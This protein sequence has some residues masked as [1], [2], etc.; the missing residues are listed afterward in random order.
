M[1]LNVT[2]AE[3]TTDDIRAVANPPLAQWDRGQILQ[4]TGVELPTAYKVEFCNKGDAVT[5]PMIGNADGVEIPN[6][7]VETGKP[8]LAYVVLY[9][10]DS[11]RETEYWITINVSVRP[12]PNDDVPDPGQ[13]SEVDQLIGALNE[14]VENAADSAEES[15]RQAGISGEYAT[16]SEAWA[17]GQRDGTDVDATDETY[18]NNSKFWSQMAQQAAGKDG[19]VSFYIDDNGHLHYVKTENAA[20]RFYIDA[21]GHLH[22]TNA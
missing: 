17:V 8:I 19:W 18:H 11:D 10:G 1:A 15:E 7:L 16:D 2:V 22:A 5:V 9:E 6:A 21:V 20:L 3:L 12:K 4:I 13:Q 14:A